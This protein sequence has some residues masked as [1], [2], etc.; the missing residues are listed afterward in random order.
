M[1]KRKKMVVPTY[2]PPRFSS[3]HALQIVLTQLPILTFNQKNDLIS[4]LL[5]LLKED[6]AS[7]TTFHS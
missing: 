5:E 1:N 7:I 4:H 3:D 2:N 6:Y